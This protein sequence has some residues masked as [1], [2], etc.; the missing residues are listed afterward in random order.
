MAHRLNS[1]RDS[2]IAPTRKSFLLA[3]L[4]GTLLAFLLLLL[5]YAVTSYLNMLAILTNDQLGSNSGAILFLLVLGLI[6]LAEWPLMLFLMLRM[7]RR[8]IFVRLLNGMHLA[9]TFFPALYG[10]LGT[11]LTGE[12]WWLGVM[13]FLSLM[14]LSTSVFINP[15]QIAEHY[16]AKNATLSEE[17][18]ISTTDSLTKQAQKYMATT[19][20][21]KR[22]KNRALNQIK[23]FILDMDGVLYRGDK[24]RYGAIDFV[25]YLN[26]EGIPYVCLTNNSSRTRAMQQEKL[27]KLRIPIDASCVIGSALAT[28]QWLAENAAPQARVLVVGEAGLRE[29]VSSRGFRLVEHAPADYVVVGIDFN[30]TYERLK[31]AALAIRQNAQFI[32]TNPDQTYPSEEGIVPGTGST[33]AFLEAATSVK[34]I[35]IGKP[36]PAMMEIA[37]S[38][39]NLPRE[40]V[41]MVGDRLNTDILGGQ[42]AGMITI[43]L[44][45]G[46]TSDAER[47]ASPIKPDH[48]FHDLDD[49]MTFY[50]RER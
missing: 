47:I 36:Q 24:V 50:R 7:V 2:Q 20:S 40:H 25:K 45:G 49:L 17:E 10:V 39:L 38:H 14:R 18:I 33:L 29:E 11:L 3:G 27:D 8:G 44:R 19:S 35:I 41:A 4:A 23:G 46:V 42:N 31:L 6:V 13:A 5:F 30:L 12:T 43:F 21:R 26:Q 1:K 15:R 22:P 34:P 37:I 32:G 48:V 16:A 28:A 9:Y